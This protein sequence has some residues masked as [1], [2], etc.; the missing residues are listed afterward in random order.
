[1]S[2]DKFNAKF[3]K[4]RIKEATLLIISLIGGGLGGFFAMFIYHHKI[5]KNYFKLVFILS[6]VTHLIITQYIVINYIYK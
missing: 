2:I 6:I 3:H 4:K 5:R 1:M